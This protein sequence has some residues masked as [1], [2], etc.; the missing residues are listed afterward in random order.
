MEQMH[1]QSNDSE[2]NTEDTKWLSIKKDLTDIKKKL[3][4]TEENSRLMKMAMMAMA[5]VIL[6]D[7]E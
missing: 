1:H 3:Y 6:S 2:V 5:L 7:F 4:T